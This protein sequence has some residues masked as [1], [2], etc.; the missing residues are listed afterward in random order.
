VRAQAPALHRGS[1]FAAPGHTL[2]QNPQWFRSPRSE[3]SQPLVATPSQSAYPA[4]HAMPHTPAA[5]VGDALVAEGHAL[6]EVLC[7]SAA[8]TARR[9]PSHDTAPGVHRHDAHRPAE[10]LAPDAHAIAVLPSP[11]ALHT[12]AIVGD[13]QVDAPGVQVHERHTPATHDSR[14]AQAVGVCASP[15]ALQVLRVVIDAHETA[16]GVQ[17]RGTH[18]PAAQVVPAA[19]G[20]VVDA[21]PSALQTRALPE[22]SHERAP[23]TQVCGAQVR[24]AAQ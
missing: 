10:Q 19:Q 3:V 6:A 1:A 9:V 5:Q 17:I 14:A 24:S 15:S 21:A 20:I 12:L 11:S 18:T 23:G 4:L 7:P 2:P 16:P 22:A 13:A 8:Q